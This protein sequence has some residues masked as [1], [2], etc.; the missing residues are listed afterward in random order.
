M[1][2]RIRELAQQAGLYGD[3]GRYEYDWFDPEKFAKLIMA[4]CS[5]AC[6]DFDCG[7]TKSP[8]ELIAVHF[9]IEE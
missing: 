5:T 1:N 8:E 4:E 3:N 6:T 7:R 2:E 9:G